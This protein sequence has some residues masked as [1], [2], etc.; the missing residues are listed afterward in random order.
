MRNYESEAAA[1]R[2]LKPSSKVL[3]LVLAARM[4]DCHDDWPGRPV[5]FP[6]L[7]TL[8]Q[9]T[10]L[11]ERMVRYAIDE[12]VEAKVIR[13]YKEREQGSRWHHNVYEWTAPM[14]P[15]YKP[16]WM[17]RPDKQKSP[18]G[19]RLTDEGWEYCEKNQ[20]GPRIAA[21]E[22]PE[23]VLPAE[24]PTLIDVPA[25]TDDARD[26]LDRTST[27]A[28]SKPAGGFAEWWAQYP[29]KV[30]KA[31]AEKAYRAVLKKGV[32]PKELMDGL[33]RQKAAWKA[34]N[35]ERQ[36]IPYPARWLRSGSW[37]DE[38]DTPTPGAPQAAPVINATTGKPVTKEDFWYACE[39]HGIDPRPYVNFWK[40]SM[41]IPGDP[42]WANAQAYL[43]RH[44]GRA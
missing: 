33:Q 14:S 17:K 15:N 4:N 39:K 7:D 23:F 37:E 36:Y 32:T 35:T 16:N 31:D 26:T 2:G 40:P 21:A 30:K 25:A 19:A 44:T 43:D 9:D 12:L 6:G 8:K 42:G 11:Q 5:C 34:K 29:K 24:Q 18:V 1:L 38:L 22:H 13:V 41:G 27:K 3:A 20:V 28:A 10:D